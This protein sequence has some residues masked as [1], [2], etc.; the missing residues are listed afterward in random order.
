MCGW[1]NV[2][3]EDGRKEKG[4]MMNGFRFML[5]MAAMGSALAFA[6]CGKAKTEE[7]KPVAEHTDDDGHDHSKHTK[8]EDHSGHNH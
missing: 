1:K 3:R 8:Q 2:L 7:P 4:E 6:G 5:I